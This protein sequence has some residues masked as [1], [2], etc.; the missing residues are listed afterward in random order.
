MADIMEI[1]Y[2]GTAWLGPSSHLLRSVRG[3]STL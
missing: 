2:I 1:V 3:I